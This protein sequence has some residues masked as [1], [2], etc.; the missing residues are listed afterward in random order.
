MTIESCIAFDC[1]HP[2]APV[3]LG[4]FGLDEYGNGRFEYGSRYLETPRAFSLDPIHLP[5][6][7]AKIPVPRRSDG[8]F[9]VFSDAGPNAWGV[10][11]ILKQ[12]RDSNR[13]APQNPIEWFLS[14]PNH[15]SGCLGFSTD[16]HTP[17]ELK[18]DIQTSRALSARAVREIEGFAA[19][20][21]ARFAAETE[22]LLSPGTCLGGARPKTVIIHDGTEHIAKFSR[23]DDLFDVPAAEFATLRLATRAGINTP[24]FELI[25]IADRSVL[26]VDRFDRLESNRIHYVSAHSILDPKPLSPNGSEYVTSFS[27][28]EIAALLRRYGEHA[29]ADAHE[30]FRR[31]VLNIMVGNVDDHLRN[32]AFLMLRPGQYRLSPV[33]DIVPHIEAASRPQSIGVGEFGPASTIANAL[34]QC[35]RFLLLP[36]E[37]REIIS[38]VKHVTSTWRDEF[39]DA[40]IAARDIHTLAGCFSV[41]DEAERQ[42]IQVNAVLTHNRLENFAEMQQDLNEHSKL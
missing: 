32:H 42:Q 15:G 11:L 38:E 8:T 39:R 14:S 9:G 2:E 24:S 3:S 20:R 28:G 1:S 35:G 17:P 4:R 27:Y 25:K 29:Q 33:F 5:L 36:H 40:G 12:M 7:A 41:A 26:L 34:S 30:L 6:Q 18:N 16:H 37:A 23:P 19:G 22:Y 21:A 10:Q 31:M 13:R